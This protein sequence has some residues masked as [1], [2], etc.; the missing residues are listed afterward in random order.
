MC[1]SRGKH[2]EVPTSLAD[3]SGVAVG[4]LPTCALNGEFKLTLPLG[5][6]KKW[7]RLTLPE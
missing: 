6:T 2:L 1:G 5:E 7:L 3:P 4:G